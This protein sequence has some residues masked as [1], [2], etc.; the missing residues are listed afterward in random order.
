[1]FKKAIYIISG[2][3]T[4]FLIKWI[5]SFYAI[6]SEAAFVLSVTLWMAIWWVTEAVPIPVTSL[7]PLI[8]FPLGGIM[9]VTEASAPYANHLVFLF[10]GG[11]ILAA[12]IESSGLHKRIALNIIR[13]VG[14][15]P[16]RIILGFMIATAFLSMW[17]SNT[18]TAV[19]MLPIALAVSSSIKID[20]KYNKIAQDFEKALL[21]AI[22]YSASIGGVATLI[23]TPPNVV[24]AGLSEKLFNHS[25][26]FTDWIKVGLPLVLIFL[27]CTWIYLTRVLFKVSKL[28]FK[29]SNNS[30]TKELDN[31][32]VISNREI[33]ILIVFSFVVISWIMCKEKKI[34]DFVIPGLSTFFPFIKDSTIAIFGAVLL[35]TIPYDLKKKKF[36]ITWNEAKKI[37]W[38]V[39][40]LFGGGLSLASAFKSSGLDIFLVNNMVGLENLNVLF[41]VL[42]IIVCTTFLTE[43]TSNTAT[44]AMLLPILSSAAIVQ[45]QH[46]YMYMLPATI[47]ASFA[48]MM[49]VAT[50]PNAVIFGSGKLRIKEMVKAGIGM[51]I[52]AIIIWFAVFYFI[53]IPFLGLDSM[54]DWV[55]K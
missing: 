18:A 53:A 11:F 32:K 23:G 47:A 43:F 26:N 13:F 52:I 34:G 16:D 36:L 12:S 25:V 29:N 39:I 19:M 55:S 27:P 37:P 14:L 54:P 42:I 44:T 46:P 24:M 28:N 41:V 50:P 4:F 15:S 17:I 1:M 38:G 10:L 33:L 5:S 3:L 21:L 22:A 7:L 30:I 49:P 40:I 8:L 45:G 6:N 31:L 20:D 51:N 48:F 9:R 2:P 35:F